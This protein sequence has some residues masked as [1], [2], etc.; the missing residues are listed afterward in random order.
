MPRLSAAQKSLAPGG[1]R[2]YRISCRV[3]EDLSARVYLLLGAG[4]PT[5]VDAG[6]GLGP[7]TRHIL[8]GLESVQADFGEA[9]MRDVYARIETIRAAHLRR[10]EYP[11]YRYTAR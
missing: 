10:Q 11:V 7:C 6:S 5:L 9:V 3:F 8:T 2:I 1:V 4:P